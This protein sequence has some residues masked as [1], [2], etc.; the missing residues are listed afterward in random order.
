MDAGRFGAIV[1]PPHA[2]PALKLGASEFLLSTAGHSLLYNVLGM[3]AGVV[4]AT[5]VW[6]DEESDGSPG[7]DLAERA[8]RRTE[9]G[10]AGL[11]VGVQVAARHWREDVV[12]AVMEALKEHYPGATRLSFT[13]DRLRP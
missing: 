11:P 6:A 2:L 5:R 9:Q 13:A 8:A 4:A 10:S 12:L 7:R 3:P 1:C